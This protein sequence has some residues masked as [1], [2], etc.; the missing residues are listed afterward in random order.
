MEPSI[1]PQFLA[2]GHYTTKQSYTALGVSKRTFHRYVAKGLVQQRIN[3]LTGRI[4]YLG[5]DLQTLHK[6]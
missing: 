1:N 5:K 6:G 3:K 2:Y 4:Y